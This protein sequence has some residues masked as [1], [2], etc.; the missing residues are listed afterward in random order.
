MDP[1]N[2]SALIAGGE[3]DLVEF[4]REWWDLDSKLGKGHFVKDVLAMANAVTPTESGFIVVGVEDRKV[5]GGVLGVSNTPP[6]ETVAQIL[7]TYTTPVP[8]IRLDEALCAGNKLSIIE[9]IWTE[10]HPYFATRD[11]DTV[12]ST[13]AV[14]TRRAGTVGRLKPVEFERLIRAKETRLGKITELSPLNVGFV[15]LPMI[16]GSEKVSIRVENITEEPVT[17]INASVDII[18]VQYRRAVYRR[19]LILDLTLEPGQ[20]REFDFRT[21]DGSYYDENGKVLNLRGSMGTTW[22]DLCLRLTY[23]GRD[24]FLD[25]VIREASLG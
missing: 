8:R 17:N 18:L 19:R 16:G 10:Y 12:L 22:I 24:G 4:K 6:Q 11:V 14:Y 25:E 20:T 13:D 23:R 3:T 21:S 5:G 2:I 9:V 15:E 1:K 7:N